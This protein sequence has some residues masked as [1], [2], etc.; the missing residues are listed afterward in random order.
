M[1]NE[2]GTDTDFPDRRLKDT[3]VDVGGAGALTGGTFGQ[4]AQR[5]RRCA[6]TEPPTE[7]IPTVGNDM[8]GTSLPTGVSVSL[9]YTG[10][11]GPGVSSVMP[12]RALVSQPMSPQEQRARHLVGRANTDYNFVLC[13]EAE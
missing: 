5:Q 10:G 12:S 6:D 1:D 4:S 9:A 7:F 8:D 11:K 13:P 3:A 2:A